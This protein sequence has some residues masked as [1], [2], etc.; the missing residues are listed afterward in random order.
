[1]IKIQVP[2]TSANIGVGFDCLGLAV[3]LYSTVYF[4]RNH[5]KLEIS[6]CPLEY[7][8]ES[9]LIFQAFVKGCTYL[10]RPVPNL[11][12]TIEN[13]IPIARGLGSSAFCIVAGLKGASA[14]FNAK[15]SKEELLALATEMEGHPDNVAPAIY[16][17]MVASF[18]DQ[19]NEI[20]SVSFNVNDKLQFI[21]II[22]DYQV[23]TQKA[24]AILPSKMFYQDTTYQIG[25]ALILTKAMEQ[26]D[27]D[28]IHKSI[29]DKMHEP[30]R[31]KLIPDYQ[32]TKRICESENGTMYISGS[33]STMMGIVDNKEN[34][35][36][37]INKI[38]KAHPNWRVHH[39][40]LDTKG[41]T[42]ELVNI[43]NLTV[44]IN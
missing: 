41:A 5:Q 23:S 40:K 29:V 18:I 36:H 27:L 6:G 26:G 4:E 21:T 39:L 8:N 10:N 17:K 11:K 44:N 15:L 28:L 1:M 37:I 14:W 43:D 13:N 22:P 42:N 12:I 19:N 35:I 9:N 34:A 32:N 38:K 25:H 3:S 2:A 33:G 30:Y 24:R 16:G 7:Q 31:S 20:Q